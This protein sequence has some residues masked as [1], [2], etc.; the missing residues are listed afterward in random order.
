M[1]N[2]YVRQN[3]FT[4]GIANRYF[5]QYVRD[6]G[7]LTLHGDTEYS[8]LA[9]CRALLT[10]RLGDD[11]VINV[12]SRTLQG[13][14]VEGMTDYIRTHID[15]KIYE[16]NNFN[17]EKHPSFFSLFVVD[18]DRIADVSRA[19]SDIGG[20]REIDRVR[21]FF[22]RYFSCM[23][24]VD[25]EH[26]ISIVLVEAPRSADVLIRYVHAAQTSCLIANPWIFN[27]EENNESVTDNELKLCKSLAE[28][29]ADEYF[30]ALRCIV[31]EM[32]FYRE[33]Q[34]A[35]IE[36]FEHS[37]FRNR[38]NTLESELMRIDDKIENFMETLRSLVIRQ[39]DTR[40]DLLAIQLGIDKNEGKNP[41]RDFFADRKDI[42]IID[43]NDDDL[44]F[45]ISTYLSDWNVAALDNAIHN[46]R[47]VM[48]SYINSGYHDD[49]EMLYTAIFETGEVKVRMA[50]GFD[51]G[52]TGYLSGISG[53]KHLIP[54]DYMPNPHIEY[55]RCLGGYETD[56]VQ[57]MARDDKVYAM[58]IAMV[59]A[60]NINFEDSTV[61]SEW[62]RYM[63]NTQCDQR[64]CF[65]LPDG[66][67]VTFNEVI[68]WLKESEGQ[69][70]QND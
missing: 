67:C 30:E 15:D 47:S 68:E 37:V 64:K 45:I 58:E 26:E 50:A 40:L 8:F 35:A 2:T 21:I 6:G 12:H 23:T 39:R 31:E 49:A 20:F 62:T 56:I 69:D 17:H 19:I 41:L 27:P 33:A 5:A 14:S 29:S 57:A 18:V 38:K 24:L 22:Q 7:Q 66:K 65:E 54:N 61:M 44:K 3:C 16:L 36:S 1:F 60:G 51:M 11:R 25:D 55:H 32:D 63:F 70:E 43:V 48:F 34:Q 59:S 53:C 42:K 4:D 9:T 13:M 46:R 10:P 52:S 28:G